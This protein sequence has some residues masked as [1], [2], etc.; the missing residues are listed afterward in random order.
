MAGV[1]INPVDITGNWSRDI[2]KL[3]QEFKN[4]LI[5]TTSTAEKNKSDL[6][7]PYIPDAGQPLT[8]KT[9]SRTLPEVLHPS[10]YDPKEYSNARGMQTTWKYPDGKFAKDTILSSIINQ[11][12]I[13]KHEFGNLF[14]KYLGRP[15]HITD[16]ARERFF[17]NIPEGLTGLVSPNKLARDIPE[18]LGFEFRMLSPEHQAPFNAWTA[19]RGNYPKLGEEF[20][21]ESI[22]PKALSNRLNIGQESVDELLGFIMRTNPEFA[23]FVGGARD[24]YPKTM[25]WLP[26]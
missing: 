22:N 5:K 25:D 17:A 6:V 20:M 24:M 8:K 21:A 13:L 16:M 7:I 23:G 19:L 26:K 14:K 18:S 9:T 3:P 4:F 12:D 15:Q 10:L 2:D 11:D 1:R